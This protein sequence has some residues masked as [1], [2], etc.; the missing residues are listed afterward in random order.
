MECPTLCKALGVGEGSG[1]RTYKSRRGDSLTCEK[2]GERVEVGNAA[3]GR[4]G[5]AGAGTRA[6]SGLSEAQCPGLHLLPGHLMSRWVSLSGWGPPSPRGQCLPRS[7]SRR[8]WRIQ[9]PGPGGAEGPQPQ[10]RCPP[11]ARWLPGCEC[12]ACDC[13]C[14]WGLGAPL[15]VSV[16]HSSAS[17][18]TPPPPWWLLPA[19]S[20]LRFAA[21]SAG[22]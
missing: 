16:T 7:W 13:L 10:P 19:F 12:K 18:A 6:A 8:G 14:C 4:A 11:A 17:W 22:P 20:L 21:G 2:L 9:T 15:L 5:N 1:G 3:G